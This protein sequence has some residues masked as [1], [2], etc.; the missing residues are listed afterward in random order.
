MLSRA[1]W[2]LSRSALVAAVVVA[3]GCLYVGGINHPPEVEVELL[4]DTNDLTLGKV[5]TLRARAVDEEDDP[6]SFAWRLSGTSLDDEPFVLAADGSLQA[7]GA[8][9]PVSSTSPEL[10]VP[11][12]RRGRYEVEAEARDPLGATRQASATFK[13]GNT[14]PTI[15]LSIH[16]SDMAVGAEPYP[17]SAPYVVSAEVTDDDP[18]DVGCDSAAKVSWKIQRP[19]A[20]LFETFEDRGC[21]AG[22]YELALAADAKQIDGPVAV[23][24]RADV[25]DRYG[26]VGSDVLT[27]TLQPN[28]PPCVRAT[29][30]SF[31][32]AA[33]EVIVYRPDG[34]GGLNLVALDVVD[35]VVADVS[36]RWLIADTE[37]GPYRDAGVAGASLHLPGNLAEPGAVRFVRLVVTDGLG[38]L[39]SCSEATALCAADSAPECY[40]WVTWRVEFR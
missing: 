26:A 8:P 19:D 30:P 10:L 14:P 27:F 4:T 6:V 31:S 18:A 34:S 24:I 22:R 16:A 23:E 25:T 9:P 39:P 12:T 11:L 28:R 13:V 35:D 7:G 32:G 37:Q 33:K 2:T 15:T 21:R 17:A 20:A 40:G 36:Y 1:I 3:P 29:E 38:A 5:A